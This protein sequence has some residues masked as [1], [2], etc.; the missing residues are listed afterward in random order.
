LDK[1]SVKISKHISKF[2]VDPLVYIY[3]LSI[4]QSIFLDALKIA[5]IKSLFKNG[6][7]STMNNY[8]PISMLSNFSKIF[9]KIIKMR[10][11]EFLEKKNLI[12]KKH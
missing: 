6:D 2:V 1:L 9:S 3:S 4:V 8:R 12:S 10:L 11:I 7:K 5:D